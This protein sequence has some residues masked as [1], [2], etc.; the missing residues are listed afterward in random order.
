[1]K[2]N[3]LILKKSQLLGIYKQYILLVIGILMGYMGLKEITKNRCI[4][5]K[6]WRK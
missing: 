5:S 4:F 3:Y 2:R 1:M 6:D